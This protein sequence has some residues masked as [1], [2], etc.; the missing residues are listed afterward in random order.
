MGADLSSESTVS[1][2]FCAVLSALAGAL[3][4]DGFCSGSKV[5]VLAIDGSAAMGPVSGSLAAISSALES[6]L[7]SPVET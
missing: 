2:D 7:L 5:S 4:V 3:E 1:S 6:G